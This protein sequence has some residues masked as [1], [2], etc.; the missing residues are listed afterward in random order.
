MPEKSK[1]VPAIVANDKI[2]ANKRSKAVE[3]LKAAK[4]S[5]ADAQ[6][7]FIKELII[8]A[9]KAAAF[10][11]NPKEYATA[12]N[13][14]LSPDI[15]Q[16][17]TNAVLFDVY[18]SD[19][20][21]AKLSDVGLG[22]LCELRAKAIDLEKLPDM[23]AKEYAAGLRGCVLKTAWPAAVAAIAAVV[24]AAASVVSMVT[25]LLKD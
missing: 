25:S 16:E 7:A 24:A 17:V 14:M 21:Q 11:K 18:L 15:V 12:E 6:V 9:D 3:T 4:Y 19:P 8:D 5:S 20:L 23:I 13:I 2:M 10:L 22:D 1:E